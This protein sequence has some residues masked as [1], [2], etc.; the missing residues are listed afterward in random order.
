MMHLFFDTETTG[1]VDFKADH[2]SPTQPFLVQLGAILT[3]DAGKIRGEANLLME[4]EGWTIPPAVQ[5]IHGI[6]DDHCKAFG[7]K[8]A[9][10]L[11]LFSRF[12]G[13]AKTLV[14]HNIDFDIAILKSAC[15]RAGREFHL[16]SLNTFCT[17]KNAT[18]VVRIPSARGFKW[19]NLQEAHQH[20][21]GKG[22]DGAHDAMED[23]RACMR[24]YFALQKPKAAEPAALFEGAQPIDTRLGHAQ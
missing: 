8:T 21:F 1:M 11:G 18:S 12:C 6:S 3:D 17:M 10:A 4:P 9:A 2:R 24:V 19:P 20:F 14:A 15:H 16:G 7:V 13:H 22:F 23:V 5:A